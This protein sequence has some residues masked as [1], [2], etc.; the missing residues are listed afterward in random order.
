L[1][2][3]RSGEKGSCIDFIFIYLGIEMESLL[4]LKE[5]FSSFSFNAIKFK[6][7]F[8][9]NLKVS[10]LGKNG[11]KWNFQIF[12]RPAVRKISALSELRTAETKHTVFFIIVTG[13]KGTGDLRSE[14]ADIAQTLMTSTYFYETDSR[15]ASGVSLLCRILKLLLRIME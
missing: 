3:K 15:L 2:I 10:R 5:F 6:G 7:I 1:L 14:Y 8:F 11:K 9:D 4:C 12:F 13:E